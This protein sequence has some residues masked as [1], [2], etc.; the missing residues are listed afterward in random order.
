MNEKLENFDLEK[1]IDVIKKRR[2]LSRYATMIFCLFLS[3]I[4]FN[5]LTLP[6]NIVTGGVNGLAVIFNYITGLKPS[7]I[8]FIISIILLVLSYIYLG[9]ERTSGTIVATIVYPIFVQ[10][11]SGIG[12]YISIETNDLLVIS[13]FLGVILGILNGFICKTGFSGGGLPAISQIL[14]KK[15]KIAVGRCTFFV[16]GIVVL[17]G[18]SIFGWTMV[19]YSII[20]LY[21]SGLMMD[22]VVLGVSANKAFYIITSKNKKVEDFVVKVM[23]HTV[24]EFPVKG[25]FLEKRKTCFLSVIP[26]NEYFRFK[27]GIEAIDEDAFFVVCDAYQ[28]E[29]GK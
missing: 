27:E 19:L 2:L 5:V 20:V 18:A 22:K 28:V 29:G 10:L 26:T 12:N 4:I 1:I 15:F 25:G 7:M 8:I 9:F 17:L 3:S 24:T 16:N 21:I 14:H 23:H 6:S 11:T 13:V